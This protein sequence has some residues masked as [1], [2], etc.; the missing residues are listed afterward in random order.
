MAVTATEAPGW[1]MLIARRHSGGWLWDLEDA[2]ASTYGMHLRD[3]AATIKSV[4]GVER[5][6]LIALGENTLHYHCLLIPRYSYTPP[7]LRGAAL[8]NHA[9]ELADPDRASAMTSQLREGLLAR[10]ST[11]PGR[12]T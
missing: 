2:E 5:V 1:V 3:I 8:L 9:G 12:A 6:Y 10:R 7:E 4:I 11:A